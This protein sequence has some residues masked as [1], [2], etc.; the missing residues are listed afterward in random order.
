[1]DFDYVDLITEVAALQTRVQGFPNATTPEYIVGSGI[2]GAL[3]EARCPPGYYETIVRS[4]S[5][6]AEVW[7]VEVVEFLML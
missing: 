2:G 4:I 7:H 3:F 5:A 1:M 6:H